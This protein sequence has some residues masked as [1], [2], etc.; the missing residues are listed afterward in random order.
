VPPQ[1]NQPTKLKWHSDPKEAE[2]TDKELG[3]LVASVHSPFF[4]LSLDSVKSLLGACGA[5]YAFTKSFDKE[6][7]NNEGTVLFRQYKSQNHV[8]IPLTGVVVAFEARSFQPDDVN[9]H[10]MLEPLLGEPINLETLMGNFDYSSLIQPGE[11]AGLAG[12]YLTMLE[13]IAH[14]PGSELSLRKDAAIATQMIFLARKWMLSGFL[15]NHAKAVRI[16]I[17]S[18]LDLM[19]GKRRKEWGRIARWNPR[20]EKSFAEPF[21]SP[22][23]FFYRLSEEALLRQAKQRYRAALIVRDKRDLILAIHLYEY[24]LRKGKQI[25]KGKNEKIAWY[26][27]LHR[28]DDATP[29]INNLDPML[30]RIQEPKKS[31]PVSTAGAGK[32]PTFWFDPE[33]LLTYYQDYLKTLR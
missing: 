1:Q 33:A 22:P 4:G 30:Q 16:D 18:L 12:F 32:K 6:E 5:Q 14:H 25:I 7:N 31:R 24:F 29:F 10:Q 20:L 21:L 2:V 27:G 19:E 15:S 23:L 17:D 11:I 28:G 8:Y 9:P 26:I 13:G 3:V